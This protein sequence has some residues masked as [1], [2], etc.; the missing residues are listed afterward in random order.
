MFGLSCQE[1]RQD[2]KI[3]YY[4][5]GKEIVIG[6]KLTGYDDLISATENLLV[7]SDDMLR[8]A[9]DPELIRKIKEQDSSIEV[10]FP[11][12]TEFRISYFDK[13]VRPDRILIPLSGEFAGEEDN[14]LAVIFLGYPDYSSGPYTNHKGISELKQIIDNQGFK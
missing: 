14:P 7:G 3:I 10:I 5:K 8:L 6:S 4:D 1:K 11:H 13:V 12:P 2:I 9:V